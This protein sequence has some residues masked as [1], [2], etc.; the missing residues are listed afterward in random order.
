MRVDTEQLGGTSVAFDLTVRC[1]QSA[2]NMPNDG[3]V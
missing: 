3:G 1:S 2:L